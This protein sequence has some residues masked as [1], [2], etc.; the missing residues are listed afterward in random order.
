VLH[1][2]LKRGIEGGAAREAGETVGRHAVFAKHGSRPEV[3]GG[4]DQRGQAVSHWRE[5]GGGMLGRGEEMGRAREVGRRW[6]AG[7]R[8]EMGGGK[9]KGLKRFLF[10]SQNLFLFKTLF[11]NSFQTS[12]SFKI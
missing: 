4:A 6:I 9:G 5:K 8:A 12:N 11:L 2:A 1:Y 7:Q 10:F 3:G